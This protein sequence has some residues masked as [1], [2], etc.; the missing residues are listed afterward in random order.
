MLTEQNLR[1][2]NNAIV[3]RNPA[4]S[5]FNPTRYNR[6]ILRANGML[7][8]LGG[9]LSVLS[10]AAI[11][12]TKL[13]QTAFSGL[14]LFSH[15]LTPRERVGHGVLASLALIQLICVMALYSK[16]NECK[17]HDEPLCKLFMLSSLLYQGV[18]LVHW[19]HAET[20]R[21]IDNRSIDD[22]RRLGRIREILSGLSPNSSHSNSPNPTFFSANETLSSNDGTDDN[23]H[24]NTIEMV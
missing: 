14:G 23:V 17:T 18:D 10:L 4:S 5:N 7:E 6:Q 12:P 22:V 9:G 16:G 19:I 3:I 8:V 13:A 1:N 24:Q 21:H 11:I 15:K 2:H 20:F